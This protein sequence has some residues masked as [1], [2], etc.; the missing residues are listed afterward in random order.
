[1]SVATVRRVIVPREA[2]EKTLARKAATAKRSASNA[3]ASRPPVP[4][5]GAFCSHAVSPAASTL[6]T[7]RVSHVMIR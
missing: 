2:S 3:S 5:R 1:M 4:R 7:S 6:T